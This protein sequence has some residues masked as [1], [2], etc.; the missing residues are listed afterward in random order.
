MKPVSESARKSRTPLSSLSS[1]SSHQL[2]FVG[3]WFLQSENEINIEI[4][5]LVS[6]NGVPKVPETQSKRSTTTRRTTPTAETS[7]K[8]ADVAW[9]SIEDLEKLRGGV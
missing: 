2:L 9:I 7:V 4:M 3:N 8:M 6:H 5:R 1:V